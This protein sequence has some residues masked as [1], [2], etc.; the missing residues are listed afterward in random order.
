M[1]LRRPFGK[2]TQCKPYDGLEIDPGVPT[3]RESMRQNGSAGRCHTGGDG[4]LD[5]N[6]NNN[7]N[8]AGSATVVD[9][10]EE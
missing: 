1:H 6:N 4:R 10:K 9:D 5:N 8:L 3:P 2:G 7:N